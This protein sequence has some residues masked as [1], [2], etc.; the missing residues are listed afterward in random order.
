MSAQP[1]NPNLP[2]DHVTV[3]I[4]GVE[5]AVPKGSM[6]IQAADKAGIPIP[7]FCYHEKLRDRGE[8]PH[9][10]GRSRDGRQADAQAAPACATPV[11]DGM[12]IAHAQRQS[13]VLAAQRDGIPADQP[14]ARLPDLRSGRRVRAAGSVAGLRP[15]GQPLPGTQA[16][17]R[18]RRSRSA[19]RDR[20][21]ALHPVHALRAFHGRRSPALTSSAA[22]SAARICEIGTYDGK[23]L[24]SEL[25][26]NVIDVCPVG[27]LT[28]KVFRFRARAVG[29][30]RARIDRLSTMRWASNLFLHTRRG[31]V[32]RAVPR[33]NEAINECWLS[34]RDRY[35]HQGL[36]AED[37]AKRPMVKENGEWRDAIV[38]RSA[39]PRPRRSCSDN[40][41]DDLGALVHPADFERG[42]RLARPPGRGAGQRTT[43]SPHAPSR[44]CP[45][46]RPPKS[47]ACRSPKS[48]RRRDR[49][50]RRLQHRHEM[51]LLRA[52]LRKAWLKRREDLRGQSGRLRL[53]VRSGR[54]AHVDGDAVADAADGAGRSRRLEE[55]VVRCAPAAWR[56]S[57][58]RS[59]KTART[60]P[61]SAPR[62]ARWR[63]PPAPV[64]AASRRAPTRSAC[65]ATACC[66]FR[67]MPRPCSSSRAARM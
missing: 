19:G 35:S 39:A 67:A 36:Y 3:D 28:N 29:T 5:L 48:K 56:S 24:T 44:I 4:D 23:P 34:D 20:N 61:R 55:I 30:D 25:S 12:K 62:R 42:G 64:C 31:D 63:K 2:P 51:P 54:Q 38:G 6:I 66:R 57:S 47:S 10:H 18:R 1:V 40:A 59:P 49:T 50:D 16:R 21:D 22:C 9:V 17:G 26:G 27:A 8:L 33:D 65:R 53:R 14:S 52:R 37:R 15:L 60:H 32:M 7:R 43:R 41:A 11:M 58:A 46:A 13:A 45:T